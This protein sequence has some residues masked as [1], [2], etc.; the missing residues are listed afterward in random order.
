MHSQIRKH[1]DSMENANKEKKK[2]VIYFDLYFIAH[3]IN[4]LCYVLSCQL[5]LVCK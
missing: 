4:T 5:H 3:K 1:W 2:V